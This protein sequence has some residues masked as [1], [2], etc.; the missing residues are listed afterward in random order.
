MMKCWKTWIASLLCAAVAFSAGCVN[1]PPVSGTVSFSGTASPVSAPA[2]IAETDPT[3]INPT[4]KQAGNPFLSVDMLGGL[5]DTGD[6]SVEFA[7]IALQT[8]YNPG[9]PFNIE[10]YKTDDNYSC[11]LPAGVDR[12]ALKLSFLFAGQSVSSNGTEVISGETP[13][14]FTS[15][16]TLNLTAKDGTQSDVNI[17]LDSLNTGLPSLSVAVQQFAEPNKDTSD[18]CS[19]YLGGGDSSLCD[20]AQSVVF[21]DTGTVKG[22]GNTSW[23]LPKKG[24]NIKLDHKASLLGMPEM[25]QWSLIAN[26]EDKSLLR[27]MVAGYLA[28]DAG[29][30]FNMQAHP[31]DLWLNGVYWGT[32]DLFQKIDIDK[33]SVNITKVKPT[34]DAAGNEISRPAPDQIGYLMEFDGHVNEVP[35]AEKSKWQTPVPGVTYDPVTQD[36]FMPIS[37]GSKWLTFKKAG[38]GAINNDELTYIRGVILKAV[39]ALQSGSYQDIEALIDV[40]SFAK[41]YI[42]EEYINNTDSSMHSS[43][44]MTLDVGGKLKLSPVWDCDR[45]CGNCNYWN[46]QNDPDSLYTSGAGWFKPLFAHPEARA[47]LKTEWASFYGKLSALT[48][49][50]QYWGSM[51]YKSQYWNFKKWNILNKKVG[52]NPDDVV[53]ANTFDKQVTLLENYL[54]VRAEALNKFITGLK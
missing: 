38:A 18:S 37:I 6:S 52:A 32:Y 21:T 49:Q 42:V 39:A 12:T 5:N 8:D 47:I 41:W 26:Y 33:N 22:R 34:L 35:A 48:P 11:L 28:D 17:V 10:M 50:I 30:E 16:V 44:Y 29:L 9:L 53:R 2:P 23:N 14:D 31:V 1:T 36:Y 20:F 15:Q 51:I 13:L 46:T 3:G 19:F 40:R 54:S 25:T 24:Y 45:S 7:Y 43:V 4:S 27:N